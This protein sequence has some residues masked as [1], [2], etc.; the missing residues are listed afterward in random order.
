MQTEQR[1]I[2]LAARL[3]THVWKQIKH[4]NLF[5]DLAIRRRIAVY[6]E[7]EG[8]EKSRWDDPHGVTRAS[9]GLLAA[10]QRA[11]DQDLHPQGVVD[12]IC[13]FS[14]PLKLF[15]AHRE[16][17]EKSELAAAELRLSVP[18][19]I[20]NQAHLSFHLILEGPPLSIRRGTCKFFVSS[21][22]VRIRQD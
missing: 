4:E 6:A 15:H 16:G 18:K 3:L 2:S 10:D 19:K 21:R 8:E 17:T 5:A 12:R 22:K 13:L 14:R 11:L 9:V 7:Y 1:Q 20:E